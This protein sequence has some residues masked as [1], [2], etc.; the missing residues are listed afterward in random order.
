MLI[1]QEI[2]FHCHA[3]KQILASS[4]VSSVSDFPV[5]KSP[6]KIEFSDSFPDTATLKYSSL[7]E[8]LNVEV[9]KTV[10]QM[11]SDFKQEKH[12]LRLVQFLKIKHSC[13]KNKFVSSYFSSF[14]T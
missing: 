7:L 5:S 12:M 10:P 9:Y 6:E 2:L 11:Y 14:N 13:L 3:G 8:L 1:L 4:S